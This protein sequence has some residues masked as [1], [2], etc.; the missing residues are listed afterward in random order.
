[1][2]ELN[3]TLDNVPNYEKYLS[4]DELDDSSRELAKLHQDK[5]NILKLG[6]SENGHEIIG[7]KM[8]KGK[9]NG[10][11]Y[12]FPNPEEPVGGLVLEYFSKALASERELEELDY[13]WY[14]IKCIDPDGAKLAQGYLKGPYTPYNF[15]LNY[16]RTPVPRTG[17]EN[18]PYRY[19]DLD[20]NQ[21]TAETRAL[22][23]IMNGKAFDFISSLHN[24][25]MGFGIT[26][27]VSDP[28]PTLYPKF[29]Q[30]AKSNGIFLRK[31]IGFMFAQGIQLGKYFTPVANYLKSRSEE[32]SPVREITG[33]YVLEYA[34]LINP[35]CFMMVPEAAPWYDR[36]CF[37]DSPSESTL[38]DILEYTAIKMKE[39]TKV[40]VD[41][42]DAVRQLLTVA[43]PFREMVEELVE[44]VRNPKISV[45]DP[46]PIP[47][48]DDLRTKVSIG[49][50][51]AAEGRADVV[52]MLRL[53][54][55]IR[56]L[57]FQIQ[58]MPHSKLISA[59]EELMKQLAE[60]NSIVSAK[61]DIRHFPLRN[62]V[63]MN[64]GS[65]LYAADYAKS[66][67]DWQYW[68]TS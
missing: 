22:M 10:L 46:D 20:L 12:G 31:R 58:K 8:G 66:R 59:K 23:K 26:F 19:G 53:G 49:Y 41:I 68:L 44:D 38:A 13:T 6:K 64:L 63:R 36:R 47:S 50:K 60:Y 2:I 29:H 5:V 25:A 55:A 15:A 39:T 21:P 32:R 57:D 17:E 62:L 40:V 37:D 1:L 7:L 4:V 11:V 18:F 51:I 30:L 45:I 67:T 14:I 9:H 3:S 24:M 28:C 34:R 52:R 43:S 48:P 42:Y 56:M 61:Y 16:Y 35:L 33:A 65:I 54:P 27:Q